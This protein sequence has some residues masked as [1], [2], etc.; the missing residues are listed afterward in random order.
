[1]SASEPDGTVNAHPAGAPA[2]RIVRGEPTVAEVAAV[3]AVLLAAAATTTATAP[4]GPRRRGRWGDPADLLRQ[5]LHPGPG[6]WSAVL[7]QR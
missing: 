6:A 1:M 7:R 5:P 2:L 3:T 4:A